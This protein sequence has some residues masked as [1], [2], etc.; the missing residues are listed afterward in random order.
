MATRLACDGLV[1]N[2]QGFH[3][4]N[5]YGRAMK[6]VDPVEEGRFR[7]LER[8]L[9]DLSLP[10]A[11]SAVAMGRVRE[12]DG[13]TLRWQGRPQVLAINLPLQAYFEHDHYRSTVKHVRDSTRFLVEDG[14]LQ[15]RPTSE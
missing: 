2:P 12:V 6:F 1:N 8:D 7:A 5:L 4:A 10:V 15:D 9:A 3:N 11:S 14:E 13:D